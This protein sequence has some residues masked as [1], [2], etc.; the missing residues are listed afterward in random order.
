MYSVCSLFREALQSICN[1]FK[2]RP[3]VSLEMSLCFADKT[4]R[5]D[6]YSVFWFAA[7]LF[8]KSNPSNSLIL[9]WMRAGLLYNPFIDTHRHMQ[10]SEGEE[11]WGLKKSCTFTG[12]E[13]KN[14]IKGYI[15]TGY[16]SIEECKK[17]LLGYQNLDVN[18]KGT[19]WT[20]WKIFAN[21]TK[22]LGINFCPWWH[23]HFPLSCLYKILLWNTNSV[24]L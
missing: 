7:I 13:V 24:S 21:K 5:D 15:S 20:F 18:Q 14:Y 23:H 16:K 10:H 2:S 22:P 8:S 12:A 6:R 1:Y 19:Q 4:R 3:D 17:L 9:S 11:E